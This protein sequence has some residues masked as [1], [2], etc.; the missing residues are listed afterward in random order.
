MASSHR[1]SVGVSMP[2]DLLSE[3]DEHVDNGDRSALIREA[4][5]EYI[6]TDYETD[7]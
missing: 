7:E 6:D 4:V 2:P 5:R 3:I 1:L